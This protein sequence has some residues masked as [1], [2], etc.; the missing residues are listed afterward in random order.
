MSWKLDFSG[1]VFE[2]KILVTDRYLF[3]FYLEYLEKYRY[4][5]QKLTEVQ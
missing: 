5:R 3:T 1:K 2:E 4:L